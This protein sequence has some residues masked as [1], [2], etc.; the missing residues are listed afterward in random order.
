MNNKTLETK[1]FYD[2]YWPV[3]IP[4]F[5]K[6]KEHLFSLLPSGKDFQLVLDAG[7]GTGVCSLALAERAKKVVAVDIS[8]ESLGTAAS[9]AKQLGKENIEFKEADLLSLPFDDETF[10]LVFSWGVIHHTVDPYKAMDE[11]V[12]VT[13]KSGTLI[14]AVYLKTRL[15]FLHEGIRR[16]CLNSSGS[17]RRSFIR[18]V[19]LFVRAAERL[20]K[21]DN[22]RADNP[23]IES[24]VE[25]WFF[26]PLKHFFSIEE[27]ERLFK[28]RGLTFELLCSQTGRFKSSSNFIVRG[29][30]EKIL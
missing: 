10:D 11:L 26:V 19:A 13:K 8:T 16:I 4:D 5:K 12:R 7:C 3:N 9:L 30:R 15:T 28:E 14:L 17:A 24:Q 29:L 1:D 2:K 22:V 27:V 20:G 18:L 6:T 21:K 23:Q 25:D